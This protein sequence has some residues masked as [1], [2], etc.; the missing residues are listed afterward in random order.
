VQRDRD[1]DLLV[2]EHALQVDVQDGVLRRMA[3]HVLQHGGLRHVADLEVDDGRVEALVVQHQQ[4]LGVV[5]RQG[6]RLTVATVEDGGDLV[7]ATQAAARTF[8][9]G[10]TEL[11]GE[12]ERSLHE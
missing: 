11:G 10:V 2:L 5:E 7:R 4:Q 8:A 3:L 1:A 12:F 9:L 6:A